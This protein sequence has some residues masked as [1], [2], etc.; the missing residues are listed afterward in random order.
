VPFLSFEVNLPEFRQEGL[1]CIERLTQIAADGVF[2]Y[3]EDCRRGVEVEWAGADE[4]ARMLEQC[5][6]RSVEVIWRTAA[7]LR[8]E[9]RPE[10][11]R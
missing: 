8:A 1:L 6:S 9:S 4:A 7:A 10:R 5:R 3:V 11:R 2:N